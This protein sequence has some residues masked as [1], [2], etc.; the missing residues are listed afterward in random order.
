MPSLFAPGISRLRG[1]LRVIGLTSIFVL[2]GANASP[3][4]DTK[5][6][7]LM[8]F[9][10]VHGNNVVFVAGEDIWLAPVQGGIATR[11][12]THDGDEVYPKFSPDGSLIAFTGEYDGNSDVYVMDVYG[13]NITRVT[14]HPDYDAVIG[15]DETT[16]K[17]MFTSTRASFRGFNRLFLIRP[18]G[19]G[20]EEVP[21][22]EVAQASFS[23]DGKRIAFCKI[24]VDGRTWKRY[25][26]GLAP[27]VYIYDF[28]TKTEKNI[29]E[30]DAIDSNPM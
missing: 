22:P 28:A 5:H 16:N 23:P 25:R 7:F 4:Q 27:D 19:S 24:S 12:T 2:A 30:S 15:W 20:L 17:I 1:T 9:P 21:L 18:D 14:Y 26:G 29:S 3:G 13:G 6:N 10:D 8:R 11:L